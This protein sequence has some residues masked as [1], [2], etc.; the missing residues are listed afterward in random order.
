MV[1]H[2]VEAGLVCDTGLPPICR[3][4]TSLPYPAATFSV[5]RP[6]FPIRTCE[7]CSKHTQSC[8]VA[9]GTAMRTGPCAC[10]VHREHAGG[11]LLRHG[12]YPAAGD[13]V[14][15]LGPVS[16]DQLR[17]LYQHAVAFVFPSLYEGFGLTPLEAMAAGTPVIAMPI[18]AV[19]EVVGDC[20]L[21]PD[22]L[23]AASL[24]RAMERSRATAGCAMSCACRGLAHVEK[25]RWEKTARATLEVVPLGR[26]APLGAIAALAPASARRD[27]ALGRA[28]PDSPR[29][30]SASVRPRGSAS[31]T[32]ER[33]LDLPSHARLRREIRRFRSA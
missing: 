1:H 5:S 28:R 25:F 12:V 11:Y 31:A 23:S 22:G 3:F 8:A 29:I 9:G 27:H 14:R 33:A 13:G 15:L 6:I 32:P 2:G 16:P 17:V 24:A 21:Y 20:A 26:V 4:A 10:R 18:S 19:P 7:T 30:P